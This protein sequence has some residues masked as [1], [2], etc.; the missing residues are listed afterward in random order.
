MSAFLL[1]RAGIEGGQNGVRFA[2]EG[3]AGDTALG[4]ILAN[5]TLRTIEDN[6][7]AGKTDRGQ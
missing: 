1:M 5:G 3:L 7:G 6:S 4:C 2:V